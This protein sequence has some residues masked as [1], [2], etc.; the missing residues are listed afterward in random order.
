MSIN[1]KEKTCAACHAYL[2]DDDDVVHCP[3]CGAPHH[4]DCYIAKGSCA[5]SELHNTPNQYDA[6]KQQDTIEKIEETKKV[7]N[8]CRFCDHEIE[9]DARMCPY[10]GRPQIVFYGYDFLGG[11]S[12]KK[13]IDGVTAKEI[14]SFVA[15][16]THRYIPKFDHLN[17]KRKAS[18][19]WIAFIFPEGWFFSRKMYKIGAIMLTLLVVSQ[20]FYIPIMKFMSGVVLNNPQEQAQY[21]I[22]NIPL[23]GTPALVLAA[24]S[25][26]I[27]IGVRVISGIL[28]DYFY[29]NHTIS[30]IKAYSPSTEEKEIYYKK[31]GGFN[32]FLFA[33]GVVVLT[34][35]PNIILGLL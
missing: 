27:T 19:N 4:R 15:V 26:V 5:L 9:N 13:K 16:N 24:V 8:R 29:K 1:N 28:G 32:I 25:S 30:K 3:I 34:N 11:I 17:K 20:I 35:L 22:Q 18:W 14:G 6:K 33:L 12:P 10:C 21:L 2:F 7:E 31:H 23:L